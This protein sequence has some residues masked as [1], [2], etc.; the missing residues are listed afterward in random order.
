MLYM[1]SVIVISV[2]ILL[3]IHYAIYIFTNIPDPVVDLRAQKYK[4]I[5]ESQTQ[6]PCDEDELIKYANSI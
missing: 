4:S 1:I 6:S 2:L 5:I 3:I